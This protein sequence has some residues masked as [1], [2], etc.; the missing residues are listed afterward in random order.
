[1][2]SRVFDLDRSG[3]QHGSILPTSAIYGRFDTTLH[4]GHDG[5]D[6]NTPRFVYDK[7][8]FSRGIGASRVWRTAVENNPT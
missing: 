3:W 6:D 7:M 8:P 2:L 1:M 5:F 4:Y